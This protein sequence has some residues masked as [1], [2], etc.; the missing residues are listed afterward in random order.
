[1]LAQDHRARDLDLFGRASVLQL[2]GTA[3]TPAGR[4][5][6]AGWLL[7][8]AAPVELAREV[9]FRQQM[10]VRTRP[11]ENTPPDVEPFLQWAEGT[12][13]LLARPGLVWLTRILPPITV[14]LILA[15]FLTPLPAFP[16]WLLLAVNFF[17]MYRFGERLE[18]TFN[19][20]EARERELRTYA[21]AMELAVF[22]EFAAPALRRIGE[23]LAS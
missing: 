7:Q 8:P 12:P 18:G 23:T 5:R 21:E 16:A 22:R 3:H 10:E 15:A 4:L 13:W 9:D 19:R 14:A 6:L 2:L 20:I 11:M 17:L 1:A